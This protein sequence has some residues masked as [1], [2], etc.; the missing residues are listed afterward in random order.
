MSVFFEVIYTTLNPIKFKV[1]FKYIFKSKHSKQPLICI[2][3]NN[4]CVGHYI[5]KILKCWMWKI[6]TKFGPK[7]F[8]RNFNLSN[9]TQSADNNITFLFCEY[10][11]K[12]VNVAFKTK[13]FV[14]PKTVMHRLDKLISPWIIVWFA[15]NL[16]FEYAVRVCVVHE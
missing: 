5:A 13:L 10:C 11:L 9:C 7:T 15:A 16:F 1:F 2:V 12:V 4:L 14:G 3:M 6:V 8:N